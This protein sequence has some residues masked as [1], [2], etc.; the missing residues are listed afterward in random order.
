MTS[1]EEHLCQCQFLVSMRLNLDKKLEKGWGSLNP[2]HT[3]SICYLCLQLM[4]PLNANHIEALQCFIFGLGKFRNPPEK[5]HPRF[6]PYICGD[7]KIRNPQI[8]NLT[9][10]EHFLDGPV[11]PYNR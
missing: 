9:I 10:L 8:F 1:F 4:A 6:L 5:S 7:T 2:L 3:P 11:K